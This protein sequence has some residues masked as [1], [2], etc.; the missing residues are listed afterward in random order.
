MKVYKNL[1]IVENPL[2]KAGV[3]LSDNFKQIDDDLEEIE[4]NIEITDERIDNVDLD[5]LNLRLD[6]IEEHIITE[7]TTLY[8]SPT[9]NDETGNGTEL[10]P[11]YSISTAF[12]YLQGKRLNAEVTILLKNGHYTYASD[13]DA[14]HIDGNL[15]SITSET[16]GTA[17]LTGSITYVSGEQYARVYTINVDN[18]HG[19]VVG[20]YVSIYYARGG[21][22]GERIAG[23]HEITGVSG[24]TLTI[25]VKAHGT[26]TASGTVSGDV[27]I[28]RSIIDKSITVTHSRINQ[29]RRVGVVGNV[30]LA[31]NSYCNDII[32]VGA[33]G[34]IALF[35]SNVNNILKCGSGSLY[36]NSSSFKAYYVGISRSN[37]GYACQVIRSSVYI[38]YSTIVGQWGVLCSL[39]TI[40]NSKLFME[41]SSVYV[42][43]SAVSGRI[44]SSI[45]VNNSDLVGYSS[46]GIYCDESSWVTLRGCNIIGFPTG[47]YT[48]FGYVYIRD[49]TIK[50]ASI[51]LTCFNVSRITMLTVT[52]DNVTTLFNP[53]VYNAFGTRG[54]IIVGSYNEV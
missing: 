44:N 5:A 38:R 4:N 22:N 6:N 51:G 19:A 8:C 1:E 15:I 2:G 47:I 20:D 27:F 42:E 29:I 7:P 16:D 13:I 25:L 50:D 33:T 10:S 9:G 26:P 40:G 3:I 14:N 28:H 46:S 54:Q 18:T 11:W 39:W 21:T 17:E 24:S 48:V 45:R 53:D 32:N 31:G 23:F 49:T 12:E 43:T 41:D 34:A 52:F 35:G 36:A 37:D 30:V